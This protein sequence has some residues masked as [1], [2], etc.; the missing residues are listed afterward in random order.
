MSL[1]FFEADYVWARYGGVC[2]ALRSTAAS[3]HPINLGNRSST[4]QVLQSIITSTKVPF[5][6]FQGT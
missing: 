3:D 4:A 1:Y 6:G 2:T 5:C